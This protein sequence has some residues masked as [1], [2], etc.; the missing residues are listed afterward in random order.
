MKL[1]KACITALIVALVAGCQS[2]EMPEPTYSSGGA[3]YPWWMP[4]DVNREKV[5]LDSDQ[6]EQVKT[7]VRDGLKDPESAKFGDAI[8]GTKPIGEDEV[9]SYCGEVNA[10]NSYGGYVGEKSFA[11]YKGMVLIPEKAF[12]DEHL[13]VLRLCKTS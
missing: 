2:I 9:D 8:Y 7:L 13:A 6:V 3:N 10:K 12:T 5:K 4:D 11:T 1:E